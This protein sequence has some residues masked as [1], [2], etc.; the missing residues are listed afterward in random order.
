MWKVETR[1]DLLPMKHI[2]FFGCWGLEGQGMTSVFETLSKNVSEYTTLCLLG[3]NVYPKDKQYDIEDVVKIF[4]NLK[5]IWQI[6]KKMIMTL[7]NHE[8][9]CCEILSLQ[10]KIL[11]NEYKY[12]YNSFK[13]T[14]IIINSHEIPVFVI[15]TNIFDK[16]NCKKLRQYI[17][18]QQ[19]EECEQSCSCEYLNRIEKRVNKLSLNLIGKEVIVMG[20]HP[21]FA[22]KFKNGS[23]YQ[24]NEK[25]LNYLQ[26]M[27]HAL[28]K[29]NVKKIWYMCADI[30]NYQKYNLLFDD[31]VPI[32]V[33]ISGTGGAKL[34]ELP[35]EEFIEKMKEKWYDKF[36]INWK[37]HKASH[38]YID[39]KMKFGKLSTQFVS[40]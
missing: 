32:T 35:N 4:K 40:I 29:K 16:P 1:K 36:L 7:G 24:Q 15:D 13:K 6:C 2:I 37:E 26:K 8:Y 27:A 39:M 25:L 31:C 19:I 5:Q 38:G 12:D 18:D 23:W 21:P 22:L 33:C 3:D 17:V 14:H 34:D 30:H 28:K 20:H 9:H 11:K 10:K